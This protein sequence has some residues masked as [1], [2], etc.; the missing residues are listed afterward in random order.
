MLENNEY[1][2]NRHSQDRR[3]E[4]T[5]FSGKIIR[6][7]HDLGTYRSRLGSRLFYTN[8]EYCSAIADYR[9]SEVQ[10]ECVGSSAYNDDG[11]M[12]ES[13][14]QVISISEPSVCKYLFV[15]GVPCCDMWVESQWAEWGTWSE[16]SVTCGRGTRSRQHTCLP[17]S[18]GVT[19]CDGND[20][21]TES[22]IVRSCPPTCP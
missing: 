19:R 5:L 1:V 22:C 13:G 12:D 2:I 20:E 9:S 21:E 6:T 4:L 3:T 15:I 8:G 17:N 11:F 7:D 14:F 10:L 18:L 16:C